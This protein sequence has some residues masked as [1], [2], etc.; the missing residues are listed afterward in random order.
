MVAPETF[1]DYVQDASVLL[2]VDAEAVEGALVKGYSA[3]ADLCELVGRFWDLALK[4]NC[5]IYIDRVPTDAN[6][7]DA[8]LRGKL[9]IGERLG[10]KTIQ[11]RWPRSVWPEGRAWD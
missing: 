5:S 8:P 7:A 11:A 9:H 4:Y 10:W 1:K 3:R 6:C 2:L